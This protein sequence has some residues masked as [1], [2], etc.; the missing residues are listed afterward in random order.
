MA[1]DALCTCKN[2]ALSLRARDIS[3]SLA[4]VCA[5]GENEIIVSINRSALHRG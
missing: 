5:A 2:N 1:S 4:G 3:D